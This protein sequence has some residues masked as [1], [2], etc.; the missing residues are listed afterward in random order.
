MENIVLSSNGYPKLVDLGMAVHLPGNMRSFTRCGSPEYMAPELHS[1][2]PH[3]PAVDIWSFG[4]LLYELMNGT[5][6]FFSEVCHVV[7]LNACI[8]A[9]P[10]SRAPWYRAGSSVRMADQNNAHSLRALLLRFSAHRPALTLQNM[11]AMAENA[12]ESPIKWAAGFEAEH[13]SACS[14]ISQLLDKEPMKRLGVRAIQKTVGDSDDSDDDG[15]DPFAISNLDGGVG[16]G[17]GTGPADVKPHPFFKEVDWEAVQ[18]QRAK[19]P[20]VPELDDD[21]DCCHFEEFSDGEDDD[22]DMSAFMTN[23]ADGMG[24]AWAGDF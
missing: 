7:G 11:A 24:D 1:G 14:L 15:D 21:R 5:T 16:S 3:G 6:P 8:A 12:M 17:G 23:G 22:D 18:Q 13:P 2:R 20:W 9:A 10:C 4:I 19:A